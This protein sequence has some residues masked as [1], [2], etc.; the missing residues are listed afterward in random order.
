MDKIK[1]F[2]KQKHH[3]SK[4]IIDNEFDYNGSSF[5]NLSYNTKLRY[6]NSK[7]RLVIDKFGLQIVTNPTNYIKQINIEQITRTEL[8]DFKEMFESDLHINT[9]NFNLTGF[10]YNI[11]I[12]T[13]YPVTSYL[14]SLN[15]LPRYKKEIYAKGDGITY[16]NQCKSFSVYDKL[17]QM[18]QAK[19]MVPVNYLNTNI[20]RLELGVKS[21]LTKTC[22]LSGIHTLKDLIKIDNYIL[23]IEE[24]Q[25]IYNKIHKRPLHRFINMTKPHPTVINT[26]DFILIYY[27]NETGLDNYFVSLEQEKSMGTISYKQM[28]T[29]KD[30]AIAVWSRY[31]Q[32]DYN[33]FD[34]LKEMDDKVIQQIQVNKQLSLN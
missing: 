30:K 21:R 34:L 10:D 15:F 7:V 14:S 23:M 12:Q 5:D 20:M 19:M 29:R 32:L 16:V 33:T 28:K 6:S 31:T 13:Q 11:N 27:I 17:Q 8:S 26:D 9:E 2:S 4:Q 22:N 3:L 18:R 24:Y 25:H 1:L